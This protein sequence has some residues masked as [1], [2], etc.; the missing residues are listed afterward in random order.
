MTKKKRGNNSLFEMQT[1][2][3]KRILVVIFYMKK[4]KKILINE[5]IYINEFKSLIVR[6][7]KERKKYACGFILNGKHSKFWNGNWFQSRKKKNTNILLGCEWL[8]VAIDRER[9]K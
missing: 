4:R 1:W 5:I 2:N 7:T 8:N 6:T 3:T 9:E